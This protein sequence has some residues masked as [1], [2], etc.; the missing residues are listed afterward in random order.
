M[1]KIFVVGAGGQDGKIISKVLEREHIIGFYKDQIVDF[2][3]ND[4]VKVRKYNKDLVFDIVKSY[5]PEYLY[6]FAGYHHS[7]EEKPEDDLN[8]IEKSNFTHF[9]FYSYFLEALKEYS[10][11]TKVFYSASSLIFGNPP[12]NMQ[13]ESTPINPVCIYGI[14]KASGLFLGRYYRNKYSLFISNGIL[15]NHESEYR[16]E[17]FL[18]PKVIKNAY[19]I[20]IGRKDKLEIGDLNS[21]TDWG[22]AY[23]Y[24]YAMIKILNLSSPDDFIIATGEG[25]TVREFLEIVFSRLGLDYRGYVSQNENIIVRKKPVLIG[26]PKKLI[27]KTGWQRSLSF[28]EM[29]IK[30]MEDVK[31]E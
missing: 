28:K 2:K 22:Y 29:V 18:F 6:Y 25:H 12:C 7:S 11:H 27:E 14:T 20:K 1:D 3:K 9:I 4:K 8:L 26:N 23:D 31:N 15:Y 19:D 17:R 5:K 10:P 13:D 30:I 16:G 21:I 24:V